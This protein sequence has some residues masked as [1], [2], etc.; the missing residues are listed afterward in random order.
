MP[1]LISYK[2]K[3]ATWTYHAINFGNLYWEK[4]LKNVKALDT[5]V[6][7]M[8]IYRSTKKQ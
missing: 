7:S 5:K 1:Q 4:H 2:T 3:V 6:V 8:L